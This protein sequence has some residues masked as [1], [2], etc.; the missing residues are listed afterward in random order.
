MAKVLLIGLDCAEPSLVFDKWIQE[1]PNLRRLMVSGTYGRLRSCDPPIT[2]PA[3]ACMMTSR[4]PGELGV[5]GFRNRKSHDYDALGIASS[6]SIQPDR[7]WDIL[8]KAGR[9]VVVVGVPPTYP[10]RPVK[11]N[12]IS[13]FLTPNLDSPH[14]YPPELQEEI[15]DLVGE[16]LFDIEG[17]RTDD[18][19][20]LLERIYDMTRKRFHVLRHLINTKPW[21]FFMFVEMGT[22]RV[23]HGFWKFH[24]PL[25]IKYK[26]GKPYE[27]AI[28]DYYRYL[29]EEIGKLLSF[30]SE[31]TNIL[32][33][34]DHGAKRMEGGVCINEWLISEKY[35]RLKNYPNQLTSPSQL[36]FD[37]ERTLAWG[38]GGYYGRIYLNVRG[39][40]PMGIVPSYDVP[41]VCAEIKTGLEEM[42]DES[43]K[44]L[45]TRVFYPHEIYR[46]VQ[47]AA[48]DLIA[49]FGNL[50]WRSVGTVGHRSIHTRENDTGPDDANH[51]THG[52]FIMSQ[53]QKWEKASEDDAPGAPLPGLTLYDIAPTLLRLYGLPDPNE[54]QGHPIPEVDDLPF[55][56]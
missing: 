21:D 11:G 50:D 19:P 25:H 5:Y 23:H 12:L 7:V 27:K 20:A 56:G 42:K 52:I 26:K 49:Y 28:R 33:V 48:P 43:G 35:L 29:D 36:E 2:V 9:D 10:I 6:F 8:G 17:F 45:G 54:M 53:K 32:V 39:R 4:D 40:E 55:F 41:R 46:E 51:D 22:D 38:E 37:W 31:D 47:G 34:S 18:K 24:D 1:L 13:C 14:T 16:Y 44:P 30:I 15:S 3:W